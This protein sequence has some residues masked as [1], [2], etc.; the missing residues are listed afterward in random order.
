MSHPRLLTD[1][2]D[3][4]LELFLLKFGNL[5]CDTASKIPA[6]DSPLHSSQSHQF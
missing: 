5:N 2:L 1:C 4:W 3:N 6:I